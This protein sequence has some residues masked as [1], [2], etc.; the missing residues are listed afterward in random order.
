MEMMFS[1][2]MLH[3]DL[4]KASSDIKIYIFTGVKY[5]FY[6]LRRTLYF[7]AKM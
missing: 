3:S 7:T 6:V 1:P 2:L 5:R 4:S